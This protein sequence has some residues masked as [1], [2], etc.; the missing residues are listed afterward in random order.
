MKEGEQ[1]VINAHQNGLITLPQCAALRRH[2]RHHSRTHMYMLL[3]L[4]TKD[5]KP[6]PV[7]EKEATHLV[8]K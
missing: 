1:Y 6:M 3:R 5:K 8:G 4:I 2:A 7:A